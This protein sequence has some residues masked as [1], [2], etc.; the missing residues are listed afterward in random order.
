MSDNQL[1]NWFLDDITWCAK[2]DCPMINCMRNPKNMRDKSG[3]HS[4]A[5]FRDTDECMI[6]R[7]EKEAMRER[8]DGTK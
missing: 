4:Y 8:E 1:L 5:I 2:S 3:L 6:Y 7:M